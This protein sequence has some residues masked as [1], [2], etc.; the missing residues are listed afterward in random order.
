MAAAGTLCV[1]RSHRLIS[2]AAAGDGAKRSC[3]RAVALSTTA[4]SSSSSSF[5]VVVVVASSSTKS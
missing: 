5:V 2:G 3:S 4:T 1:C